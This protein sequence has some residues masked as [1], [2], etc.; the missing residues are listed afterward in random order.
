M[1]AAPARRRRTWTTRSTAARKLADWMTAPDN[2]FFARNI[3]NRF[4]GYLMGRGLVEPLDDMRATNPAT[5]P[6]L[7]DALAKDFVEHKFD[8]KHLLR[9]IMNSRAYQLS[10]AATPGNEADAANIHYTRYTVQ[11]AD[12]RAAGRRPRL[13]HRHAREVRRPAAGHA[14]DPAAR[15]ARCSRTCWT[16]SA[17]RRGRSPANANGPTQP[18]IAQALHLLNGDFLNKKIADTAGRIE[19]LLEAKKPLPKAIEELYLV[20]LSRPP[21]AGRSWRRPKGWVKPAPTPREGV[22]GFAL[23]AAELARVSV[24]PVTKQRIAASGVSTRCLRR[25]TTHIPH[26]STSHRTRTLNIPAASVR[27]GGRPPV[28]EEDELRVGSSG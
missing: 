24:Q 13:R 9:T 8:L 21:T 7:L 10:S 17:G 12:G 3:V 27:M 1:Q 20:T 26:V 28:V 5:N 18:N 6:E 25:C 23:G 15:H 19:K 4:W 14:G 2:P 11:A 16:C 22:A